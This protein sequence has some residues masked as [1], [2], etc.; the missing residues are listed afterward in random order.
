M[1]K[2]CRVALPHRRPKHLEYLIGM[3]GPLRFGWAGSLQSLSR[4]LSG[5]IKGRAWGGA[6]DN[7]EF[8]GIW[9]FRVPAPSECGVGGLH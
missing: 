9:C 8:G 7:R 1:L 3:H 2:V 6:L 4:C 5:R